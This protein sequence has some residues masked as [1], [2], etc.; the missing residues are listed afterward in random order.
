MEE[1]RLS[2]LA[3]CTSLGLTAAVLPPQSSWVGELA[4][5]ASAALW[6]LAS[7]VFATLG[8]R[9]PAVSINLLKTG[10]AF[11]ALGFTAILLEGPIFSAPLGALNWLWVA[12]SGVIG[13]SLGDSLYF[14][15]LNYI[16]PR[17]L[18]ILWALTP[19]VTAFFAEIW[20]KEPVTSGFLL[21]MTLTLSGVG[22]A[23]VE[24]PRRPVKESRA[25]DSG[26]LDPSKRY[27]GLIL[28]GAAGIGAVLC[29]A[30]GTISAKLG[31]ASLTSLELSVARLGFGTA[32]LLVPGLLGLRRSGHWELIT[33]KEL[34]Q[35][36]IGTFLGTYLGIWLSM[37]AV[38]NAF[39][40]VV[41][42]LQATSPIFVLP[43]ARVFLNETVSREAILGAFVAVLGVAIL[44]L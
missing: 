6:A 26:V 39:A 24:H 36:S 17:R 14:V 42:T 43:L 40:G 2:W 28:G 33:S 41:A 38:Q 11:L 10:A 34:M 29:Q 8:S 18:L 27:V 32:A 15:A 16:G 5:L 20:L 3:A 31:G 9:V 21:G 25:K 13:L 1:L 37:V 4:A 12:L 30:G 7:V 22:L 44:M 19:A 23:L 35:I